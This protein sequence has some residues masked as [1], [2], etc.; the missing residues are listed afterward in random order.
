MMYADVVMEKGSGAEVEGE[1]GIRHKLES[2]LNEYKKE[3]ELQ[4]RYRLKWR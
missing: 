4:K 1:N 2:L 3:K